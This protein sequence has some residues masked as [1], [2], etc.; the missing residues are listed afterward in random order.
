M[1]LL[2]LIR[3]QGGGLEHLINA[4]KNKW[5]CEERMSYIN[6]TKY[7]S[8]KFF[9][10]NQ[11][12][13]DSWGP[14]GKKNSIVKNCTRSQE[15]FKYFW[16]QHKLWTTFPLWRVK[17]DYRSLYNYIQ[18]RLWMEL[19]KFLNTSRIKVHAI[20]LLEDNNG[21]T[22]RIVKTFNEIKKRWNAPQSNHTEP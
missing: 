3:I 15:T 7:I 4:N 5:R 18:L 16:V 21:L 19:Q 17:K 2:L 14:S 22:Q 1:Y 9:T 10:I 12:R 13:T 11:S 6:S 20:Y 8:K